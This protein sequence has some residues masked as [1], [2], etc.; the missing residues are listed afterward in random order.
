MPPVAAV[1]VEGSLSGRSVKH[2]RRY[3]RFPGCQS[4]VKSQGLCQRHGAKPRKCKMEGC[5]KQAQGNFDGMCKSHFKAHRMAHIPL[6]AKV[7]PAVAAPPPP[8][9]DSVYDHVLPAS[10]AWNASLGYPMPLVQHLKDGFDANKPSA[11]HR[12]EERRARGLFPI[13]TPATQLEG[14]ERELVWMEILVL[15]GV[16]GASFRHLAR[17]WG[18][19]KGFHMVLA[20]FICE[21]RGNV[22]RKQRVKTGDEANT[23]EDDEEDDDAIGADVWDAACYGNAAYNEALA[24]ELLNFTAPTGGG[25]AEYERRRPIIN[26]HAFSFDHDDQDSCTSSYSSTTD[27]VEGSNYD[28]DGNYD[29]TAV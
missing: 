26:N 19:D 21:R 17:G 7:D 24:A 11:W 8:E 9:G 13:H 23:I 2:K 6:P 28:G 14:W 27:D 16:P 20:Q 18:R 12:N 25:T 5:S 1:I 15:T 29:A 4:I 10:I 22:E 3:C